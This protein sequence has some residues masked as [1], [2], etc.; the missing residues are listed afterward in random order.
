MMPSYN[1]H[2]LMALYWISFMV[3][4]FFYCMNLFLA[5]TVNKY[6]ESIADRTKSRNEL[7]KKLLSEAFT[8]LDHNN[9]DSISRES[10]MRVMIIL[11]H[12]IPEI[13][14]LSD[15][16]KSIM[17]AFLDRDG[18]NSI[19]LDEFL[20]FGN[21]LLLK[22]AK[23]SDYATLVETHL[24]FIYMSG[25]YRKLCKFVQSKGFEHAIDVILVGNAIT[26]GK[27]WWC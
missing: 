16:E 22:L 20:D 1:E 14:R 9:D 25:W 3:V 17:F 15:D 18:S 12:D 23:Q 11:N 6:D 7:S 2:R 27:I 5:V 21:V 8:L 13:R 26:I 10:V 24:P 19:S 4:S